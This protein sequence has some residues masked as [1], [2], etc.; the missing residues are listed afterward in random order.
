[1]KR[2]AI[3][4]ITLIAFFIC[5]AT[6]VR[7]FWTPGGSEVPAP[8]LAEDAPINDVSEAAQPD[9]LTIPEIGVDADIQYVGITA[10][11]NM[12]VPS[13]FTDV[14]WYKYG[15]VP[16]QLG[17]AVIDGHV[18]NAIGLDGV[19]KNLEKLRVGDEVFVETKGGRKLRFV[20]TEV[21][22]YGYK[23]VPNDRLFSRT[24]ARR[25]NLITCGGS[26]I[27]TEKTYDERVV[28]YTVLVP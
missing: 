12:G 25:L 23:E 7:A 28:V 15:T 10:G 5:G 6:A 8:G 4:T 20:V 27:K 9:R 24:D 26:W 14:G 13:N 1:M 21:T 11:G 2:K 3:I 19:F 22:T 18:D 17:S 16:G